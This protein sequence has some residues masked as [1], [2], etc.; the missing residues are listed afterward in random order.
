M[1]KLVIKTA[2]ITLG[3]A[4]A[5][6]LI[7]FACLA[8]FSP[9]S[10]VGFFADVGND[11]LALKYAERAYAQNDDTVNLVKVIERSVISGDDEK[12]IFYSNELF[13]GDFSELSDDKLA[14]IEGRFCRALVRCGRVNE[15]VSKAA[16]FTAAHL[17]SEA[18]AKLKLLPSED[19]IA[20]AAEK[21]DETLLKDIYV[22]LSA[23]RSSLYDSLSE[24]G[25]DRIN[26]DVEKLAEYF[27]NHP[28]K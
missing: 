27:E 1:K 10:L 22:S 5:F 24:T 20:F 17:K 11:K 13:S 15:G 7:L 28:E 16:A 9:A 4:I 25:K 6:C 19:L 21:N 8:A 12:T 23:V 26:E 14:Y 18:G 3:A 2:S